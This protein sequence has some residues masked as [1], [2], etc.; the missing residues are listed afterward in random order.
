MPNWITPP[1]CEDE[2]M[3][4]LGKTF[5]A[6]EFESPDF[7]P[8]LRAEREVVIAS[9]YSGE[10]KGCDYLVMSF[11]VTDREGVMTSWEKERLEVRQRHLGAERTH[12]F[13]SLADANRQKALIPFLQASSKLKG[14]LACIAI[15][16]TLEESNLGYHFTAKLLKPL[17]LA[18]LTRIAFFGSLFAG[19]LSAE[20]QFI[21]WIT[22][23]DEI[24]S[25]DETSK[26]AGQVLSGML[27]RLCPH[28]AGLELGIAG[29]FEDNKRAEDLCAIPDL[30]GGAFAESL[31]IMDAE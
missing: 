18:K 27:S 12:A 8:N 11:L 26:E 13:K 25:N 14:L 9:D 16:K 19:G 23:N 4:R 7:F 30:V 17:V 1:A 31:N 15:D 21:K 5:T 24:V 28:G 3:K 20:G 6:K 22:D 29:K 2:M 10:H